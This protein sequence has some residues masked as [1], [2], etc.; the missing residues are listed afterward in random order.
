MLLLVRSAGAAIHTRG[1]SCSHDGAAAVASDGVWC[2]T[3]AV[4]PF[5]VR[6]LG[7]LCLVFPADAL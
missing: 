6:P 5:H 2:P 7:Q 1:R 3:A 4:T